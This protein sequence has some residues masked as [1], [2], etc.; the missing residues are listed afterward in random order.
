GVRS[1]HENFC[2]RE[3]PRFIARNNLPNFTF[4][5]LRPSIATLIYLQ[6]RDIFRVQRLLGHTQVRTTIRYIKGVAVEAQHNKQMSEGI[7]RMIESITSIN[8]RK[9][10]ILV[11]IDSVA[12]VVAEKVKAKE[13]SPE[14]GE[15][16]LSGECNTLMGKC[17]DPFTSPQPG[18]VKGRVCRSLHACIFCE[19]CWVFEED[20]PKV[21]LYRDKL[22]SQKADMTDEIWE[23]LHGNAVREI[24]DSILPSF[25]TELVKQVEL[26]AKEMPEAT[27]V[28]K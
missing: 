26:K 17:K 1:P 10:D 11:F 20:L 25:P 22:I 18:E 7:D 24:N 14:A 19:N 5:Q 15:R 9:N 13:L 4:E 28:N 27:T 12:E 2:D 21:I 8:Y 16:M 6:T 23:M 3:L